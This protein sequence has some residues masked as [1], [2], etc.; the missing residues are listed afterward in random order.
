[1]RDGA[2]H[3]CGNAVCTTGSVSPV[4]GPHGT[5]GFSHRAP[6][7]A[8]SPTL[9]PHMRD[10]AGR[11]WHLRVTLTD[12]T[13]HAEDRCSGWWQRGDGTR[14]AEVPFHVSWQGWQQ[15]DGG[16][17]SRLQAQ[18]CAASARP[19]AW[20]GASPRCDP[21]PHRPLAHPRPKH[22]EPSHKGK[23]KPSAHSPITGVVPPS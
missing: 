5:K 9:L 19:A 8:L 16:T 7:T 10:K 21:H 1:M 13:Q 18:L 4:L 17:R 6:G 12:P 22:Q 15:A 2:C 23:P 14:R 20:G 3:P 11:R